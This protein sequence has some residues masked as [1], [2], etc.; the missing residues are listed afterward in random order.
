MAEPIDYSKTQRIVLLIDLH[1]LLTFQNPNHYLTSILATSTRLLTFPSLRNSLFAFKL[2]FSSFSPLRST[3]ALNHLHAPPLSVA[4]NHPAQ[5]LNSITET[6]NSISIP[7]TELE[8]NCSK[9]CY[10]ASSLLQ[11]VHE[12][13]WETDIES[14]P[15]KLT[16]D[17]IPKV[18]RNLVILFSPICRSLSDV[19]E[20]M[21][22][23][24]NSESFKDFEGFKVKFSEIFGVLRN[25]F[26]NRNIHFSWIDV[27]DEKK[28]DD[29]GEWLSM[30][31]N[32][33]RSFDWGIS[34]TDNVVLGSALIPFGLIYPEIGLSFDI[35]RSTGSSVR[36]S[37][38]LNLEIV[39][40]NG[41]PLEC[42]FCDLELV[43]P[44]T[45]PKLRS[46]DIL[47]TLGLGDERNKGCDQEDTFWSFFGE[48]SVNICIKAVKKCDVGEKIEGCSSSYVLVQESGRC[49]TKYCN[50][51]CVD[52]VLHVLFGEKGQHA[53]GNF[54]FIWKIVLSF[55]YKESYWALV[56]VSNSNG[57]TITGVLRPL[58][59]ELAL[60]SRI[61]S[62]HNVKKEDNYG[63]K[64]KQMNDMICGSSNE[65]ND[66]QQLIGSQTDSSTSANCEPLG[67][68][69]RKKNKK[70][71][72]RDLSRSSFL[73]AA[74]EC[75]DFELVE[76]CLAR[77]IEKPKKLKFLKCWMK[78]IKKSSTCLL[79]A[80]DSCERQPEQPFSKHFPSDSSLILEGDAQL[81]CSET[82]EAFFNNLPKKIQ[83]A[84]QSGRD[85]HTLAE[86]LVKSSIH[87]LSKKYETDDYIGGESQIPKTN[88]SY[89]K[90]VLPEL[91]KILLR[92][93][94]EMKEKLKHDN[95]SEVSDFS[96]ISENIVREFELQIL[97]R[98]EIL[99]STVS[100]S[101]KESSKQKLVKEI[102]SFLEI[103]QYLVE[104]GIHGHVSLYD[105]VE[106]TIRLR[107]HN[108]IGD[109][110]NRIYTEM[111]LLPF[112][113]EDE[114]Q[115]H[116]FNSE[117]S[118]Q[119]WREKQ[120]RYETAEANN[121]RRSVSAED[122]SCQPPENIDG[123]SQAIGGQEHARKLS[124][125]RDR[126]EKARRFGS[127]TRM[128]DLQRVWA[129]KQL[130]IVKTKYD[131]QK[132]LKR[133]ER[134]KGR[135]SVVYETPMSGRWSFSQSAGD[136][137]EK[138]KG[139]SSSVS[140]ALFQ[141]W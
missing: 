2:Y 135:D 32:G 122:E 40:V 96:S 54:T 43:N 16:G 109:V 35:L 86:R 141:D 39:D 74:F 19:G 76:V 33:I 38:Q 56:T 55:L 66:S 132:E 134:K 30:L 138:L 9:A 31:E 124:E 82:A 81:L 108:I 15:G 127:F 95:P 71:S 20:Y 100:E 117:D 45:L 103:I 139:S 106:R 92:K 58:T 69:K 22:V 89:C 59:A 51:A 113:D 67:D 48:G 14:P 125:A 119:S 107:Y 68:G 17:I 130:K 88:D 116:L 41:K 6:L 26:E 104:G 47:N 34:S 63:S 50:G 27:K 115:A 44:T 111:D 29:G 5:T 126:R 78:Q 42:K 23:D 46:E 77:H 37:A 18:S 120:E 112:G 94:K 12:Y 87:A 49:K 36:C 85:L 60:L 118:N 64:L 13:V 3:S 128:P 84:L 97:L 25:T 75:N 136:D 114:K 98:M 7:I 129:P 123:S 65:M 137:D 52:G 70:C 53:L 1:P 121:I 110:V 57:S 91:M 102:C 131:D 90:T 4:F 73:K 8:V 101:I 79:T 93:P 61:E 99:G 24:V 83:H 72:T 10:T 80:S 133:K 21:N 28:D 62:C 11:L 140:K 105:Y